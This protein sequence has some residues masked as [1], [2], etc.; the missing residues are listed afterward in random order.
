MS[1]APCEPCAPCEDL[2]YAA[3]VAVLRALEFAGKRMVP[4]SA[5]SS[6]PDVEPH[7]R[8]TVLPVEPADLD[9]LLA[10]VWGLVDVALPGRADLVAAL[11]AYARELLYEGV[12]HT[13][14]R[15]RGALGAA[16]SGGAG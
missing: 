13:I 3:H 8:H 15:L 10:D 5:R 2:L 12:P 16:L 9:R 11:D 4:R 14:E 7:L 6:V 1:P